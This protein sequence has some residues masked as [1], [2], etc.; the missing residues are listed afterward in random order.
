MFCRLRA[1]QTL[2]Q[3]DVPA[4]GVTGPAR[5][6]IGSGPASF[7]KRYGSVRV[8]INASQICGRSLAF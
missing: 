7:V 1:S 5:G 4:L 2:W 6:D 8:D 3:Q